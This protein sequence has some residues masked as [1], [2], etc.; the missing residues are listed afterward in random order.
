MVP[1][2]LYK[3]RAFSNLTLDMLVSDSLFFA[4]PTTF[5]DPLDTNPTL[6]A[7]LPVEKLERIVTTFV[8]RRVTAEME[9]AAKTIRYQGP[10]TLSRIKTLSQKK[11][12][13]TIT[14]IAYHAT[15]P[16][17]EFPNPHKA[18]LKSWIERELL[19]QYE[20]GLVSLAQRAACPLM[21]S[22]YGDQHRGLCLGYSVQED[23]A[24][25]LHKVAYGGSR[26]VKISL[27]ERMLDGD[28]EARRLVDDAVLL[29]KAKS[30]S[31]ERE[32][33]LIGPRGLQD[34]P[35]EL[36][37]VIFGLRCEASVRY[38][39]MSALEGRAQ[40]VRFFEIRS[41][42]ATFRLNKLSDVSARGTSELIS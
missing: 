23:D 10:K 35:I 27:V 21:W 12:A 32:W 14:D 18:L 5:N 6:E 36:E 41:E 29:R 22:H 39:I 8:E 24:K 17:Y 16:D 19:R 1:R 30:W 31:Y 3:Y 26:L 42:P 33:R 37:E 9:A 7:D 40:P 38:A 15:N 28:E 11:A 2:K 4:D 13:D 34:A 20:K 25:S